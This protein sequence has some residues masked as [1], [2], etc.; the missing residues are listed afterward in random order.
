M[1]TLRKRGSKWHVQVRRSGHT[2][3]RS[4]SHKADAESWTRLVERGID[5][6]AIDDGS[7][8][9][10]SMSVGDLLRRYSA[11]ILPS[12][13]SA[14]VETFIIR[15]FERH[16]LGSISTCQ[17]SGSDI[18]KYRDDRLGSVTEGTV[19]RELSLLR[20]CFEVARKE[21]GIPHK[22]NPVAEITTSP[23]PSRHRL[24][25]PASGCVA[26]VRHWPGHTC[27]AHLK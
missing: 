9:N 4:F 24:A 1:A 8:P 5:T 16:A 25:I 19:H 11:E 10:S 17:V 27:A 23:T 12:K 18:S 6:G 7:I 26:S 2:Q 14:L 22:T 15:N 3:T 20:H 21:W 13:K